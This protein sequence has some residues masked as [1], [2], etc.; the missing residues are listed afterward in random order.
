MDKAELTFLKVKS[1]L[2]ENNLVYV[3]HK[4]MHIQVNIILLWNISIGTISFK[5]HRD[6]LRE[7]L[8]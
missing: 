2:T 5:L 3:A 6:D 7:N 1:L 8:H 4:I